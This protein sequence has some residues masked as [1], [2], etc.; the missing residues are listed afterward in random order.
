LRWVLLDGK[1]EES[2]K[3]KFLSAEHQYKVEKALLSTG[4]TLISAYLD[5]LSDNI[6]FSLDTLTKF[7]DDNVRLGSDETV[8]EGVSVIISTLNKIPSSSLTKTKI[9]S[10]YEKTFVK[11]SLPKLEGILDEIKV[12]RYGWRAE[13]DGAF[14]LN[15]PSNEFE[16]STVPRWG[17]WANLSYHTPKY[18]SDGKE[19]GKFEFTGLARW[20]WNSPEFYEYYAP[21]STDF[22]PGRFFDWGIRTDFKYKKFTAGVEY[23][24]RLDRREDV[25][26]FEGQEYSRDI[27]NDSYK[28]TLN[29]NYNIKD[30]IVLSYNIGKG[31][32]FVNSTRGNLISGLTVNFGFGDIKPKDVIKDF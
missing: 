23:I 5:T 31:Y 11:S 14:S 3:N 21:D 13:I 29:I 22:N 15:F 24:Y 8:K 26:F 30:N 6:P 10:A 28:F 4:L 12:Q 19:A 9:S 17:F 1:V 16:F 18:K 27:N 32:G 2:L 7:I 25:I 20:L